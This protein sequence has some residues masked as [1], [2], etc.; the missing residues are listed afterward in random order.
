MRPTII[1]IRPKSND[2]SPV[3]ALPKQIAE[4]LSQPANQKTL[5]TVLLYDERGLR[6]Y[7]DLTTLAQEYYLFQTEAEILKLQADDIIRAMNERAPTENTWTPREKIV[8]ELGAGCAIF[9]LH[10]FLFANAESSS[11]R[12]TSHLLRS[13]SRS[14]PGTT[15]GTTSA[16]TYYALDLDKH[17]LERTLGEINA[18]DIGDAL[19]GKVE[20]KGLWGTYDDG[21][22]FIEDGG[23]RMQRRFD[24]ASPVIKAHTSIDS[25]RLSDTQPPLHILFLGSSLGNF[26]RDECAAFLRALPLRAGP[27]DT[28]LLG[29][30]HE[31]D[32]TKLRPAYNDSQ[33]MTQRFVLNALRGAGRALGDEYLFQENKWDYAS[34]YNE[35]E[36][37]WLQFF[38]REKILTCRRFTQVAMKPT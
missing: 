1:D 30:D 20:T 13:L 5:P 10:H 29:M 18:S 11:L 6:L 14:I 34:I 36:R 26:G 2:Q 15:A 4:G 24:K 21:I 3:Q 35:T 23:L 17:E 27:G 12:K 19:A 37:E 31:N 38:S 32:K 7:D 9:L 16:A 8:L 28:L 25:L 22:K 33:G